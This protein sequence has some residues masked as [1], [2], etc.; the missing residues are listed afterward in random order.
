MFSCKEASRELFRKF[1]PRRNLLAILYTTFHYLKSQNTI[2]TAMP[3]DTQSGG[4]QAKV[5]EDL[6]CEPLALLGNLVESI[7][8]K[9]WIL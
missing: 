7:H 6:F 3:H 8:S 1:P 2:H 9:I 5:R 4:N